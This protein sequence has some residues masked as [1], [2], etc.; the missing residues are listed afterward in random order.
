MHYFALVM[1]LLALFASV[2]PQRTGE[3]DP[4]FPPT[5]M[6]PLPCQIGITNLLSEIEYAQIQIVYSLIPCVIHD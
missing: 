5:R 6:F 3:K 2:A 1:L 4:Y